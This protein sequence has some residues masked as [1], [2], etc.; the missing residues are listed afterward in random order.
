MPQ[1]K[2]QECSGGHGRAATGGGDTRRMPVARFV[3]ADAVSATELHASFTA[4]F[5]DYLIG[6]F[7]LPLAQWPV[8][9]ARQGPDGIAAFALVA[10]RGDCASW[11]LGTMGALP[12]ARGCG[13]APALLDDFI[14]RAAGAGCARVELECFAQNER[15]LRLYR[16]RGFN[17]VTELHGYSGASVAPGGAHGGV[18]E[19]PLEEAFERIAA[20]SHRRGGDLPL[21][22][23]PPSL[24]AQSVPLQAWTC[25]AAVAVTGETAPGQLTIRG[26]VDETPGQQDAQAIAAHLLHRFPGHAVQVPQLQRADLGGAALQRL[27]F[28]RL[29]LHQLLMHRPL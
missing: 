12:A 10:P 20:V 17:E 24:R 5:A 13:A 21:Q 19:S 9:L 27:G 7:R 18:D 14:A 6:P 26:L 1:A 23:T 29:P 11:R 16:S 2:A 3:P 28:A 4:A 22:V 25:G 15:G 8:F